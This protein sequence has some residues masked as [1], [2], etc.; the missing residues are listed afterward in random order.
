M[1]KGTEAGEAE[2]GTSADITQD[3]KCQCSRK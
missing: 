2:T 1:A 3:T